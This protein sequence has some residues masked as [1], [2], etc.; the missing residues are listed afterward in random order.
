VNQGIGDVDYKTENELTSN[1]AQNPVR[2]WQWEGR[3][4]ERV[5]GFLRDS[6]WTVTRTADTANRERGKDIEAVGTGGQR[7]WVTVKG[8]PEKSPDQQARHWF[9]EVVYDLVRY[10]TGDQTVLLGAG[11]PSQK[12]F[13]KLAARIAW[14]KRELPFQFYWVQEDGSV[15]D[16]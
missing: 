5:V 2:P 3:V 11:L 16:E 8:Y 6:G 9:A 14:L 12:T 10:R 4:Q 7:L 15:V 13:K 1:D